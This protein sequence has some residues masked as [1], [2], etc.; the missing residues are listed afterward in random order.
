[1]QVLTIFPRKINI[2][3][4]FDEPYSKRTVLE[5]YPR[6]TSDH[7]SDYELYEGGQINGTDVSHSGTS[8]GNKDDDSLM[9]QYSGTGKADQSTFRLRKDQYQ[10]GADNNSTVNISVNVNTW[11]PPQYRGTSLLSRSKIVQ[12][13]DAGADKLSSQLINAGVDKLSSLPIRNNNPATVGNGNVRSLFNTFKCS[14]SSLIAY[15]LQLLA[16]QK[17]FF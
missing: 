9:V 17:L 3:I 16:F 5:S 12:R 1:M 7:V 8:A 4:D 13:S 15:S 10:S 14:V 6:Y 11:K 2:L